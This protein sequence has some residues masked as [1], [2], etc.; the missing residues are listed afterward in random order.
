MNL[1]WKLVGVL[2]G[3]LPGTVLRTYETEREPHVRSLIRLA[4]LVGTAMTS[5]GELGDLLRRVIAPRLHLVPGLKEQVLSGETPALHRS[6]LVLRPRLRPTLAGR[7]C[8]NP[9][10][11]GGC[12]FDDMAAGRFAIVT[13]AEPSAAQRAEIER[14]GAVLIAAQPGSQL[15]RWLTRGRAH[16]AIIRPDGTVLQAGRALSA[17]CTALPISS[18]S[19]N[20]RPVPPANRYAD[21]G[22]AVGTRR[23]ETSCAQEATS[24]PAVS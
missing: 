13:S 16:A 19:F 12:R 22:G 17:L 3:T 15:H 21:S 4:K 23:S 5:G 20:S 8:P 10:L 24:R 7:L 14:R 6:D 11:E 1:T 18:A 2:D 9:L